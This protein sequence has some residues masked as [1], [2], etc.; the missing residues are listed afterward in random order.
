MAEPIKVT[1][2][3]KEVEVYRK[4]DAIS[5]EEFEK[6]QRELEDVR[7][8]VLTP[9]YDAYLKSLEAGNKSVE[10]LEKERLAA[11]KS[12]S[13]K[14]KNLDD[15]F[16][17]MTPRQIYDKAVAD[18]A[19]KVKSEL[20]KEKGETA[21]QE[22]A[23]VKREI[24]NFAKEHDDYDTYRP[25]M[26]SLSLDPKN[27][28]MNISQLYDAAKAYVKTIQSG[29]TELEK[30]KSRRSQNERPGNSS[31]SFSKLKATSNEELAQSALDE[32]K[33]SLGPIPA[34]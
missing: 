13:E 32:V 30:E 29:S 20:D 3:G 7:L 2:D 22:A 10:E 33:S 25:L 19:A 31:E 24:A 23:R 18:A 5:K 11:E 17:N 4:E 12:V 1:I 15:E 21:T 6:T 9:Q 27:T 34:A 14:N 28:D 26:H 16:R 8:E